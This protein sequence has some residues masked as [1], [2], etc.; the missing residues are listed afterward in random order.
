MER[1]LGSR[2]R[3]VYTMTRGTGTGL[4]TCVVA[5]S[6]I[7]GCMLG[8]TES[9]RAHLSAFQHDIISGSVN[10][11]GYGNTGDK[12]KNSKQNDQFFHDFLLDD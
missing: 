9:N 1:F 11:N 7:I 12:S 10:S 3:L 8:V 2:S 4:N 5:G 6:T